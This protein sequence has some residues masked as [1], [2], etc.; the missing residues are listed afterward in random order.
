MLYPTLKQGYVFL[1]I[2]LSGLLSGLI[3]DLA[4]FLTKLLSGNKIFKQLLYFFATI[5][6]F[7][8]LFVINL[9][10]NF[11]TFRAYIFFAFLLALLI[12]RVTLGKLLNKALNKTANLK[13]KIKLPKLKRN[14]KEK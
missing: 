13:L 5:L 2:F 11:G 10:F 3:Y 6:S 4:N 7:A 12:E 9:T 8:L 1:A 14:K